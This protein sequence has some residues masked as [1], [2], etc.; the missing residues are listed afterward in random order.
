MIVRPQGPQNR[1]QDSQKSSFSGLRHQSVFVSDFLQF[2]S[3]FGPQKAS[4]NH[5]KQ[6]MNIGPDRPRS[7]PG[8]KISPI[9][10]V[11]RCWT[12]EH[13]FLGPKN[14]NFCCFGSS[15]SDFQRPNRFVV[16]YQN[17]GFDQQS[18]IS[19]QQSTVHKQ[20]QTTVISHEPTLNSQ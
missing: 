9:A 7:G 14:M 3:T 16:G 10:D 18:T 6:V 2:W 1:P 8:P 4:T 11:R 17:L 5:L 12:P 19:N 20:Q 13:R 15:K